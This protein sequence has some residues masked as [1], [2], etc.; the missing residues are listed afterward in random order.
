MKEHKA[1]C[2]EWVAYSYGWNMLPPF[3]QHLNQYKSKPDKTLK[4]FQMFY[5]LVTLIY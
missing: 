4:V 3:K 5:L 2:N 1:A